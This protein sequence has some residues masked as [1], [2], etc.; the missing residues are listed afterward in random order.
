MAFEPGLDLM[1]W[2]P[3]EWVDPFFGWGWSALWDRGNRIWVVGRGD[4]DSEIY[5]Y[6]IIAD[7]WV[8]IPRWLP[9]GVQRGH[10]CTMCFNRNKIYCTQG[11][12]YAGFVE[13]DLNT[14]TVT[15]LASLPWGVHHGSSI[16]H[17]C[18]A[19]HPAGNDDH[20]YVIRG[21][22]TTHF[23][24]YSIS[25]NSWTDLSATQPLPFAPGDGCSSAIWTYG[26]NADRIYVFRFRDTGEMAYYTI[27]TGAW[28]TFTPS[29]PVWWFIRGNATYNEGY[30]I[31]INAGW[32]VW[33]KGIWR[34]DLRNNTIRPATPR[35]F[36]PM[37]DWSDGRRMV[38]VRVGGRPYLY[39]YPGGWRRACFMR[40]L[41]LP[42]LMGV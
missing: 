40:V 18:S 2:E 25:A 16:V 29:P 31:Y 35:Y 28:T 41:L 5:Y 42:E 23:A 6:D 3:L 26:F 33:W 4:W 9:W 34:L 22:D 21:W 32:D 39:I 36:C 7:K 30:Y 11:G 15:A 20:I 8:Q 1:S 12:G 13:F 14:W 38:Y 24:R 27:S 10:D 17:T 37:W 19:L